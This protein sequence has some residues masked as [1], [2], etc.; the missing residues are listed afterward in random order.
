MTMVEVQGAADQS[1]DR[2]QAMEL[3]AVSRETLARLDRFVALLLERQAG[4]NLIASSTIPTLWVRHV[5]DSLQLLELAP[6]A[7]IWADIGTGGGFPGLVLACALADVPG[8][9]VHMIESKAKKVKFLQEVVAET[10][11]AGIVHLGRVE[12]IGVTL[13]PRTEVVTARAVAPL[14]DLL[15]L[16]SPFVKVG[17]KALLPKGQDVGAE[18]TEATKYWNIKADTVPSKTSPTGRILIVRALSRRK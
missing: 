10:G 3:V 7:R 12:D 13:A 1:S 15:T 4:L 16:V 9:F 18:L 5:A 2:L 11:A 8:A 17:A 6:E 14:P